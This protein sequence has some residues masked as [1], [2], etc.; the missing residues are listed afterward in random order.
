M[1]HTYIKLTLPFQPL[2]YKISK[3][4]CMGNVQTPGYIVHKM[5]RGPMFKDSGTVLDF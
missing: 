5:V 3:S 1:Q 2:T 4:S